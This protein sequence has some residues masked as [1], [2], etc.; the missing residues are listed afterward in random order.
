MLVL[1][2]F[3]NIPFRVVY[4]CK[5]YGDLNYLTS[6]TFWNITDFAK[7]EKC[8]TLN[9]LTLEKGELEKQLWFLIESPDKI[10]TLISTERYDS[11]GRKPSFDEDFR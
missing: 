10:Y 5:K 1:S 4:T 11:K 7:C 6:H 2:F 3:L 8:E 9:I